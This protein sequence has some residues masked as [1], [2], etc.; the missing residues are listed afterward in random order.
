MRT[1]SRRSCERR[2][3]HCLSK[4]ARADTEASPG[5]DIPEELARRESRLA[6]IERA[7]TELERRAQ[8]RD[9]AEQAEY[10]EKLKR[11]RD[12]EKATGEESARSRAEGAGGGTT[13]E[14]P[15][16]LHR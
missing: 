11:R 15:S 6:A 7:K 13:C 9:E 14:G 10:E 4:A 1:G 12:T 5:L 2:C 16:Q 3:R 8:E